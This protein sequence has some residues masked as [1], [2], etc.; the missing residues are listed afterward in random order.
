MI[1][2]SPG[3]IMVAMTIMK[4]IPFPLNS[5]KE[6][7]NAARAQVMICPIVMQPAITKE[8]RINRIR[9]TLVKA[10]IKFCTVGLW[11]IRFSS[12]VNS[13]P[14][15]MNA[16]LTAYSSGS[17]ITKATTA[18]SAR[19]EPVRILLRVRALAFISFFSASSSSLLM[20][21]W[22]LNAISFD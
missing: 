11:G 1:V 4:R 2:A 21:F 12:V 6:K 10:S 15:G 20:V 8:F 19:R 14:E 16:I 7:A 18:F 9:G 17:S 13:S 3:T 22:L 5:R